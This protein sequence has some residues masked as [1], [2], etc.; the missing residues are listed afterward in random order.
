MRCVSMFSGALRVVIDGN[1]AVRNKC[2][3]AWVGVQGC[4]K[5]MNQGMFS[6]SAKLLTQKKR[7][8]E[9]T[10]PAPWHACQERSTNSSSHGNCSGQVGAERPGDRKS[11]V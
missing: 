3:N 10:A 1:S 5:P 9:M 4:S 11:V 6:S 8:P 2:G 7:M